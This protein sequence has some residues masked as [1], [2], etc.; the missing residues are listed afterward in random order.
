MLRKRGVHNRDIYKQAHIWQ[1]ELQEAFLVTMETLGE[2][3]VARA[4][5]QLVEV[6]YQTKTGVGDAAGNVERFLL[7]LK[8]R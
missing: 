7:S 3:G 5:A 4:L 8:L 2:R 6:D 1:R